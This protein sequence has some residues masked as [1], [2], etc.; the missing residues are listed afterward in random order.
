[1][2]HAQITLAAP[3]MRE[4][5]VG[6]VVAAFE[7]DPAFRFFFD[8]AGS[9]QKHAATFAR[10]LFDPRVS[11]GTVWVIDGGA[12]V[13]MWDGPRA[14][15]ASPDPEPPTAPVLPPDVLARLE[16]YDTAV[17]AALPAEP[18]WYL[19]LLA[20]HP[21]YAGRRWGRQLIAAGLQHPIAAG[22]PAYLETTNPRN[23]EIYRSAGWEV[24]AATGVQ[25]LDIWVM[26]HPAGTSHH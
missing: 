19:G 22:L 26:R 6:T 10:R 15:S 4:R 3:A 20:T 21:A 5:V 18:Y 16:K 2:E 25:D 17:H 8:D 9:F 12:A 11:R 23:V 13:A 14:P 1:M 7:N 24:V